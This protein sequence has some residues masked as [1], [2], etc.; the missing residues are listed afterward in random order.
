VGPK[1]LILDMDTK[2]TRKFRDMLASDGLEIFR[3]G[4]RRPNMNA[5]A[6]RFVQT[7]KMEC[8]DHFV[9]LGVEHL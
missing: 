4:P 2:F 9:C 6:E 3:V 1:Q 7:I 5:H 8:L